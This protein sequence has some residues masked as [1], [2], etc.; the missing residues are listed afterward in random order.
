[1]SFWDGAAEACTE[2]RGQVWIQ[3]DRNVNSSRAT[4]EE[5]TRLS[6]FGVFIHNGNKNYKSLFIVG[7]RTI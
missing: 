7:M 5:E 1:M 4:L 6:H 3:A 2:L